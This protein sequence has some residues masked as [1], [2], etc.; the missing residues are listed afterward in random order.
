MSPGALSCVSY[1]KQSKPNL[2]WNA[3]NISVWQNCICSQLVTNNTDSAFPV[4][5]CTSHRYLPCKYILFLSCCCQIK[6]VHLRPCDCNPCEYS[7]TP[8]PHNHIFNDF[9]YHA[10]FVHCIYT[11]HKICTLTRLNV[12]EECW[13]K[14]ELTIAVST[15]Y[16]HIFSCWNKQHN[17][18]SL[19]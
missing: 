10:D 2:T 15:S 7:H 1:T 3:S 12:R 13:V 6:S 18:R 14:E 4:S 17:Y 19:W 5:Q 9:S 16:L 11:V 8:R